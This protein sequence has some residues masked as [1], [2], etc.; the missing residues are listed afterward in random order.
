M[1]TLYYAKMRLEKRS[2]TAEYKISRIQYVNLMCTIQE[3]SEAM[4]SE[5][6]LWIYLTKCKYSNWF[7]PYVIQKYGNKQGNSGNNDL[8]VIILSMKRYTFSSKVTATD[9]VIGGYSDAV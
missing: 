8:E 9:S 1:V 7:V 6:Y 2:F 4:C 5:V 3:F